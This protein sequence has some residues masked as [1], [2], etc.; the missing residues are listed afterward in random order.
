MWDFAT[1]NPSQAIA[2]RLDRGDETL[3]MIDRVHR[4]LEG[5]IRSKWD[6]PEI[7]DQELA[8]ALASHAIE[9]TDCADL[10]DGTR[11]TVEIVL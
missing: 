6:E 1:T 3:N 7:S 5:E 2:P 9:Q 11:K 10:L 4:H 8:D